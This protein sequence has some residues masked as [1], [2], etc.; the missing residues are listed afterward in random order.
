MN[1]RLGYSHSQTCSPR[2]GRLLPC[3]VSSSATVTLLQRLFCG[4]WGSSSSRMPPLFFPL[5]LFFN[6][7]GLLFPFSS[8]YLLPLLPAYPSPPLPSAIS[9]LSLS[10]HAIG[11]LCFAHP[12]RRVSYKVLLSASREAWGCLFLPHCLSIALFIPPHLLSQA[13]L[14]FFVHGLS[15]F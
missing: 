14:L 11:S 8:P 15:P 7:L 1:K 3:L 9:F 13:M 6:P 5:L 12:V 4:T 10:S 2:H